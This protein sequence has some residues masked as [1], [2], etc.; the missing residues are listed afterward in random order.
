MLQSDSQFI[1]NTVIIIL[2]IVA[3]GAVAVWRLM[4]SS[5]SSDNDATDDTDAVTVTGEQ[6][7]TV[8][9]QTSGFTPDSLS[10]PVGT[11]VTLNLVTDDTQGCI[12]SFVIPQ[13]GIRKTLPATGTTTVEFVAN[14][15]GNIVFQ[16]SMGMFR[17][18]IT[19]T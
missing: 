15:K 5:A 11:K 17:G 4:P 13:F 16:C 7:L 9:V 19:V 6:T 12:R 3:V 1:R 18:T 10:V 14:K 8:Q 2:I